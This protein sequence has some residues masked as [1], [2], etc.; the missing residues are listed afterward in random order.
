MKSWLFSVVALFILAK[1]LLW[2]RG[3]ILPLPVYVLAG[4]FL[5]IASNYDKGIMNLF[6]PEI[7]PDI[8]A[9]TASLIEERAMLESKD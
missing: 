9:Q 1:A 8:I 3:F 6:R 5:A 7:E 4:A 2:V